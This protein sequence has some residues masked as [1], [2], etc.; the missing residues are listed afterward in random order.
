MDKFNLKKYLA[1]GKL[2]KENNSKLDEG[3]F[4]KEVPQ[5]VK[6]EIYK[7][8]PKDLKVKYFTVDAEDEMGN[9]REYDEERYI[10][11]ESEGWGKDKV[12]ALAND[13]EYYIFKLGSKEHIENYNSKSF[14]HLTKVNERAFK[15]FLKKFK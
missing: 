2:L 6:A 4:G 5:D 9:Q 12:F 7:G 3:L 11:D 8:Y 13:D 14:K 15:R 10:A 1:E